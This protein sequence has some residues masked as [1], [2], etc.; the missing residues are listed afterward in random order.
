[1]PPELRHGHPA[2]LGATAVRESVALHGRDRLHYRIANPWQ[3]PLG[4]I[5][6][7]LRPI[8]L[9]PQSYVLVHGA[10]LL[11]AA[12]VG[13]DRRLGIVSETHHLQELSRRRRARLQLGALLPPRERLAGAVCCLVDGRRWQSSY[14]HWFLDCLPRL[15]AAADHEQRCGEAV[16]LLLPASLSRWQEHSLQ[17]LGIEPGRHLAQRPVGGG[18]IAVDR[19]I[20]YV[21][22]R[23]QR[24]GNAPFDAASPWAIGRLADQLS[25]AVA[26]T[27]SALP[28]RLYLSRRGVATRQVA[29]EAELLAL[30]EPHGFVAVQCERLSLSEQIALFRGASHLVAPHGASLTN[31]IHAREA[32]V[33]ELFQEDHGVRPDFFQLAMIRGLDYRH[34]VSAVCA[35]SGHS[36]VNLGQVSDF[37]AQTL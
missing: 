8:E 30:L 15:L 25:R 2:G 11:S 16:R 34:A 14:Y 5:E 24:L 23:W 4:R 6:A 9:D 27:G 22:H 36:L 33:L 19:L 31:L 18:G 10:R 32:R 12:P 7:F 3:Q 21:A 20:G 37:L 1:M 17:L 13:L 35:E 26:A 28:R 29:N